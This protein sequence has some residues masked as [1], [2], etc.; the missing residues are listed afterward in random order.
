M[1]SIILAII[2]LVMAATLII[3]SV[4]NFREKEI[5]SGIMFLVIGITFLILSLNLVYVEGARS[6]C[7]HSTHPIEIREDLPNR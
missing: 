7:S 1:M 4:S 5:A 2:F 3:L 6:N